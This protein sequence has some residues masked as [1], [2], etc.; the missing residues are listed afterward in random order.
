[1]PRRR[2]SC[3]GAPP[4]RP[5]PSKLLCR[6]SGLRLGVSGFMRAQLGEQASFIVCRSGSL[7]RRLRQ[8]LEATPTST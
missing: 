4:R 6:G 2:C 8:E 1:M 3:S 5:R 7:E